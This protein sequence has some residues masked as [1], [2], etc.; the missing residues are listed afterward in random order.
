[1]KLASGGPWIS[2]NFMPRPK[3]M[4]MHTFFLWETF[5]AFIQLLKGVIGQNARLRITANN[6]PSFVMQMDDSWES[7]DFLLPQSQLF[8]VLIVW[9]PNPGT[10]VVS[11]FPIFCNWFKTYELVRLM[12][13]FTLQGWIANT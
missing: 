1:M 5:I 11:E 8:P 3:Y 13:S 6:L 4:S 2:K 10:I 12:Y 9:A 7:N